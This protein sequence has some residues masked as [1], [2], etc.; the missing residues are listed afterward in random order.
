[1]L[2]PGFAAGSIAYHSDGTVLSFLDPHDP[3]TSNTAPRFGPG[4]VVGCGWEP[5]SGTFLFTLNGDVV[6]V[7]APGPAGA[8]PSALFPVR[9]ARP[10]HCPH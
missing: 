5:A 3:P 7:T 8:G 4:D 9:G 2:L 6:L 10:L 1:M